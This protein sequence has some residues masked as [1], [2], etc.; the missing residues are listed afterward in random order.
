VNS[1]PVKTV[2]FQTQ[3]FVPSGTA[4]PRLGVDVFAQ[5]KPLLVFPLQA[6]APVGSPK[7]NAK[8]V[9]ALARLTLPGLYAVS[10]FTA[11]PSINP[12][13]ELPEVF[14]FKMI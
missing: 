5:M 6:A 4:T 13:R 3:V 9:G 8:L 14:I 1:V 7:E 12:V 11:A 2:T 10:T